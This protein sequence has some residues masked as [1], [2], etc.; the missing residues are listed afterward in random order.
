MA[1]LS[2]SEAQ[3][4][5]T[6][7]TRIDVDQSIQ[8]PYV[9]VFHSMG[10]V[11][12]K[13]HRGDELFVYAQ[14][15]LPSLTELLNQRKEQVFTY[16]DKY[17]QTPVNVKRN[18]S[19]T[20]QHRD[21]LFQIE[22]NVFSFNSNIFVLTPERSSVTVNIKDRG[23]IAVENLRGNVEANTQAGNVDIK[24]AD[25]VISA[26]TVYGNIVGDF[27][28]QR[29]NQPLFISTLV[30]NIEIIVP[31]N[32]NGSVLAS[33]EMGS[34]ISNFQEVKNL[35]MQ[36]SSNHVKNR[37]INFNLNGG[38]TNFVL[39]SFKGDIYLRYDK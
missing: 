33:T 15:L 34:L 39:N 26:S 11:S 2:L 5:T 35:A 31:Q 12:V 4:D 25:G 1:V 19:F 37:K 30:G 38:G 16:L 8:H 36:A 6:K 14:E 32:T 9:L 13:G 22:S 28:R 29:R 7:V 20:I 18:P 23:N 21:S 24:N 17:S 10:N 27:S 3:I